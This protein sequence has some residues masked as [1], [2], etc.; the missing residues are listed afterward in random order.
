VRDRG[1]PVYFVAVRKP[2]TKGQAVNLSTKVESLSFKDAER[3]ADVLTLTVDNFDLSN[4]DDPIWAH[5]NIIQFTFGYDSE[6][7]PLREAVIRSVKGSTKLTIEAHSK[8]VTLD[9]I[10]VRQAWENVTRSDVI[11]ELA[12]RNGYQPEDLQ[13]AES[14]ERFEIL[15]Q[16]NLTDAQ[17]IRKLCEQEGYEFFVDFDGF[18]AH[19]RDLAQAPLREILYY[20]DPGQG[21]VISW[22]VEND[23]TR[24]PGRVRVKSRDP[25]TKETITGLADNETD[26]LR[27][28]L[29]EVKAL[30][31]FILEVDPETGATTTSTRKI[32]ENQPVAYEEDVAGNQQ[33]Q[34]EAETDAKRRFRKATQRAVKMSMTIVGDPSLLAKAVVK[35]SGFGT[36]LSGKYYVQDAAHE[37]SGSGGYLTSLKLIT[38][39]YQAK[40]GSG[41]GQ[42]GETSAAASALASATQALAQALAAS[43]TP[44]VIDAAK[45]VAA[46]VAQAEDL[47]IP[48]LKAVIAT[49]TALV[50]VVQ[51]EGKRAT[52]TEKLVLTEVYAASTALLSLAKRIANQEDAKANGTVNDKDVA[53]ARD[54]VA[55]TTVDP[56]TGETRT[57][58]VDAGNRGK[59]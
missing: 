34:G 48:A 5:G 35:L 38:D 39:G 44:A 7:A 1:G 59:K 19:P 2:G 29:Q 53:D 55:R 32:S 42:G 6:L 36:R 50:R 49:T 51:V 4:F 27:D 43:T 33:T 16:D 15:T 10:K 56:E 57:F 45:K 30:E 54:K 12:T 14:S 11:R 26:D 22:S 17:M 9:R 52:G 37:L 31:E 41:K 47:S 18:H 23:I 28:L 20:T 24:K 3:K 58:Y 46:A 40:R 25:D 21:D 13:I 8:D